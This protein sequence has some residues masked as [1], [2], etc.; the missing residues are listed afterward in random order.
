[1]ESVSLPM[2]DGVAIITGSEF[3]RMWPAIHI[4]GEKYG[5]RLDPLSGCVEVLA[6]QQIRRRR[7][8][9][10]RVV[11]RMACIVY[12]AQWFNGG[13]YTTPSPKAETALH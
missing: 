13:S 12:A 6:C 9:E 7:E 8:L 10:T 2:A 5:G 4:N 1:M 11:R 3:L